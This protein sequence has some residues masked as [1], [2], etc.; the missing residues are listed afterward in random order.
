MLGFVLSFLSFGVSLWLKSKLKDV[1]A[2][3]NLGTNLMANGVSEV[4]Y[5]DF[6]PIAIT[7]GTYVCAPAALVA[8]KGL[9]NVREVF[10]IHQTGV[11]AKKVVV[12]V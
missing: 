1:V 6:L 2:K 8:G 12:S 7:R 11:S 10:Q 4:I 9:E 3:F 5:G